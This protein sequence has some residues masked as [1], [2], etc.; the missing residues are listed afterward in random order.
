[1]D[2]GLK[3][4]V[5]LI[6]AA[7]QGLGRAIADEL[8]REGASLILNSRSSEKITAVCDDISRTTDVEVFPAAGD[9]SNTSELEKAVGD[10]LDHFGKIDIL[11]TNIVGPP[12]GTF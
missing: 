9:L 5:A 3:G 10:G 11:V 7:S 1:M 4:K 12:A 2:L 6:A 8:A